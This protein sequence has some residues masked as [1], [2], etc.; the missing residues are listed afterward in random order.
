M[1]YFL[2]C[3]ID[4][5]TNNLGKGIE[6]DICERKVRATLLCSHYEV[7]TA[8][9]WHLERFT[10]IVRCKIF[11]PLHEYSFYRYSWHWH[12]ANATGR[13]RSIMVPE[14][15]PGRVSP[16]R[17][18][19]FFA[20][21]RNK[22]EFGSVSLVFHYFTIK[23]HFSFFASFRIFSHLFGSN[24]SLRF[25][26]VIFASKWN[27][28]KRNS[29]LFFSFFSLFFTFFAFFPLFFAFFHFFSL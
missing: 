15:V 21:K 9:N 22:S 28:A 10:E 2:F 19:K 4:W 3:P 26:L 27:K 16:F 12:R 25:T 6:V 14:W 23:F 11:V 1:V 5:R 18:K 29:S 13:Y 20:Y 7:S 24:F 8:N 17:L